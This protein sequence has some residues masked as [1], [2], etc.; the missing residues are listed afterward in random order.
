MSTLERPSRQRARE[1][2]SM[3]NQPE[4]VSPRISC[5]WSATVGHLST[6][7][8]L[9]SSLDKREGAGPIWC[10]RSSLDAKAGC[11]P[12]GLPGVDLMC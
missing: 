7:E 11:M 10:V 1:E 6:Y 5:L 8:S 3:Q 9:G 2:K 4:V 12:P